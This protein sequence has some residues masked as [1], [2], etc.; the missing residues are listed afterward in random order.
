[1]DQHIIDPG[2]LNE[3][4]GFYPMICQIQRKTID[5]D[6][7]GSP[8][9]RWDVLYDSVPCSIAPPSGNERRMAYYTTYNITD[10]IALQGNLSDILAWDRLISGG[11][12]Y[13][14]VSVQWSQ[15]AS[16]TVLNCRKVEGV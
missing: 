6:A 14:I 8:A 3:L 4:A 11:A 9:Y 15:F 7:Y 5:T 1:M 2:L 13:D 10:V 16:Q 12:G